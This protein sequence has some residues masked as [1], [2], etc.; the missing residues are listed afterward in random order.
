MQKSEA[1]KKINPNE[2]GYYHLLF[3]KIV[4]VGERTQ[5]TYH[6][7]PYSEKEYRVFKAFTD[8]NGLKV[9]GFNEYEIVHRPGEKI[10]AET[11]SEADDIKKYLSDN[12]VPFHQKLG[13]VKLRALKKETE[14]K[15]KIE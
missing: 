7:V 12:G 8:K 5:D 10:G 3:T 4:M 13:V 2:K 9:T 14:D 15:L 6:I 1:I 11:S